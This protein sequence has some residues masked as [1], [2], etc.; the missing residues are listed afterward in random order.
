[1]YVLYFD[2]P[3]LYLASNPE[4]KAKHLEKLK[5]VIV[6]AAPLPHAD[7]GRFLSKFDVST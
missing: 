1:M 3:V 2:F 5:Y 6:G 7:V 4:V